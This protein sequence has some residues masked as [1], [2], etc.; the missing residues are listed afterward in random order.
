MA[1]PVAGRLSDRLG[2]RR[3]ALTGAFVAALGAAL[4]AA[5][6]TRV[7]AGGAW[8]ALW[9]FVVGAGLGAVGAPTMGSLYRTLPRHQVPQGSSVLYMLNQLGAAVGIAVVALVVDLAGDAD[10]AR[11]FRYGYWWILACVLVILAGSSLLPGRPDPAGHVVRPADDGAVAG[12][13]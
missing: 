6:L 11:G 10:P 9:A 1:M 3:P 5:A 2:A 7:D 4:G 8:P 12:T 13:P